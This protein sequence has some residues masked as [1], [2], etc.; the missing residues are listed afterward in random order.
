MISEENLAQSATKVRPECPSCSSQLYQTS[1][2]KAGFEF[3]TC[4]NCNLIYVKNILTVHPAQESTYHPVKAD[5][6]IRHLTKY[7]DKFWRA[8]RIHQ[9]LDRHFQGQR[10]ISLLDIG[11]GNGYFLRC[12]QDWGYSHLFGLDANHES[13]VFIQKHYQ[14]PAECSFAENCSYRD[15]QF[16][17]VTMDQVLEHVEFPNRVLSTCHRILKPGG[18]LWLSTPNSRAWHI[19]LKLRQFHRHFNGSD[20]I[21]H[22]TP[23]TLADIVER[24]GFKVLVKM[25]RIEEAS[26]ARLKGVFLHPQDFDLPYYR[27]LKAKKSEPSAPIREP[28]MEFTDSAPKTK[29]GLKNLLAPI[30]FVLEKMTHLFDLAA[31]IEITAVKG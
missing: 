26:L 17:A 19:L 22:F 30:D 9:A 7:G 15:N 6:E 28:K 14:I 16:D 10:N 27:S 24:N 18:M 31:Y 13:T 21:N 8:K 20:H 11:C 4:K 29:K 5:E 25:T 12:L 2:I 1:F 23:Q 3:V